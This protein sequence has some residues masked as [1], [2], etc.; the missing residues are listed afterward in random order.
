[1]RMLKG[2]GVILGSILSAATVFAASQTYTNTKYLYSVDHPDNWR[3]KEISSAVSFLS[4]ME[5]KEDKF[6]E[7][8]D[9]VVED[10]SQAGDVSLLDYH[11]KATG[12]APLTLKDFKI[13]EEAKTELVGHEAIAVLYTAVVKGELF[14][15][16]AYTLL[17]GKEAYVLTYKGMGEDFDKYLPVG[18]KIMRSLRVSP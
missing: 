4:P 2:L 13:L 1:M 7:N 14:R 6:A 11:R 18:E 5:S 10:L 3:V 15:F 9:I 12:H 17:A 16:K 8:V